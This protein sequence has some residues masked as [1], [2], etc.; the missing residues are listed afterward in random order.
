[1][2]YNLSVKRNVTISLDED[3]LKAARKKAADAGLSLQEFVRKVLAREVK[4]GNTEGLQEFWDLADR[5]GAKSDG[6][7]LKREE[8]YDREVLRRHEHLLVRERQSGAGKEKKGKKPA[9]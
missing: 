9:R 3:V 5:I 7:Y 1:M 4:P 8:L 2:W 6:P